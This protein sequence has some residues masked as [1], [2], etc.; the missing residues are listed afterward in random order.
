MKIRIEGICFEFNRL[1]L[2][3][4]EGCYFF[5]SRKSEVQILSPDQIYKI[6]KG[7]QMSRLFSLWGFGIGI[8]QGRLTRKLTRFQNTVGLDVSTI[9]VFISCFLAKHHNSFS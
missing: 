2:F 9:I 4:S 1:V 3:L 6:K 7:V 8:G 5:G